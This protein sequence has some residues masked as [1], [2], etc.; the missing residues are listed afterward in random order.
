MTLIPASELTRIFEYR[1]DGTLVWRHRDDMPIQWRNRYVGRTAG[2]RT[3][4]KYI[5]VSICNRVYKAHRV[6]WAWHT[7]EWP[8]DEIDHINGDPS[9]NRIE[10]LRPASRTENAI[11]RGVQS[12][13][14]SGATG[15][16]WCRKRKMWRSFIGVDGAFIHIGYFQDKNDARDAYSEASARYHGSYSR[17]ESLQ[18]GAC[19]A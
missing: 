4:Q 5:Q 11:N 9:D 1:S 19:R 3:H 12:N 18:R 13:N 7:G 2:T 6:I 15:V 17:H 16:S 8:T 14:T 10:N